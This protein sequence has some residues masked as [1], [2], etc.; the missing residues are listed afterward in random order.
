MF[1]KEKRKLIYMNYCFLK[2]NKN[3][4]LY[5][6][7][8]SALT[9]LRCPKEVFSKILTILHNLILWKYFCYRNKCSF[10]FQNSLCVRLV[11]FCHHLWKVFVKRKLLIKTHYVAQDLVYFLGLEKDKMPWFKC[12]NSCDEASLIWLVCEMT[13]GLG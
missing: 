6:N 1:L 13:F 8:Y 11:F 7:C 10:F 12:L 2:E 4:N 9:I 3:L 5:K